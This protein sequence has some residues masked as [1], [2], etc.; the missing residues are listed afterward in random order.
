MQ[1]ENTNKK[2]E[3]INRS[4]SKTDTHIQITKAQRMAALEEKKLRINQQILEA[5]QRQ[6]TM[7]NQLEDF[8]RRSAI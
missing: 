3:H 2:I 8:R 6:E 5:T 4:S 1:L 7:R